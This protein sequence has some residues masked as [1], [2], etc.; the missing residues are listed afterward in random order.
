M[1]STYDVWYFQKRGAV[2]AN[3]FFF[4]SHY[5]MKVYEDVNLNVVYLLRGF[6]NGV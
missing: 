1:S 4:N 3:I 5:F 2:T 6:E